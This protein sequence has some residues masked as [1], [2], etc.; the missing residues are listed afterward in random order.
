MLIV[1]PLLQAHLR[2]HGRLPDHGNG[3]AANRGVSSLAQMSVVSK[4]RWRNRSASS[5]SGL[6]LERNFD[7]RQRFELATNA[8]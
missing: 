2:V 7:R 3:T 6:P 8:R 5:L 4:D 1:D